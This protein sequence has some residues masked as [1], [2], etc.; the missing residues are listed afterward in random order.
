MAMSWGGAG[1]QDLDTLPHLSMGLGGPGKADQG[2]GFVCTLPSRVLR[3]EHRP[4]LGG[5]QHAGWPA[6]ESQD[7]LSS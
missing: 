5:L 2:V 7:W 6:S 3:A 1:H 4:E